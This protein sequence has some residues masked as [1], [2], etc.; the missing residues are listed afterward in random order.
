MNPM[1]DDE[2]R[3]NNRLRQDAIKPMVKELQEINKTLCHILEAIRGEH[4]PIEQM[5]NTPPGY[6]PMDPRP[7]KI[8][9]GK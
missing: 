9:G 5:P 4:Q 6:H 3:A 2:L 8:K 1:L 7:Y